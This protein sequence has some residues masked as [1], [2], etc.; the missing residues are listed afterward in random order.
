MINRRTIM[1]TVLSAILMA[2]AAPG[3]AA[4]QSNDPWYGRD[5]DY[6]NDRRDRNR[7]DRRDRRRNDDYD[8]RDDRYGRN[9]NQDSRYLRDAASRLKDR[10]RSLERN[11]DRYLDRSRTNGTRREDHVNN[12][13]KEFRQAADRFKDRIGDARNLSRSRNEAGNL[14]Q[15]AQH[16]EQML[17]S[18]RVD[19]RTYAD[20]REI[21]QDL[22]TVANIYG[23][24]YN[25]YDNGNY[26][27]GSYDPRYPD[28]RN[29]GRNNDWWRR[30]PQVLGR[31]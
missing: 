11:V 30:I 27:R 15:S 19:S 18:L 21:Q 9:N 16:V 26:R 20:W 28:D 2:L 1:L 29:R 13:V 14:L 7:D 8:D 3:R 12:D 22:R 17:S 23:L 6:R 5:D 4:A 25:D 24:N 10:S 31:P